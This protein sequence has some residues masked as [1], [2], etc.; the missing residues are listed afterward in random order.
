MQHTELRTRERGAY[1]GQPDTGRPVTLASLASL[2]GNWLHFSAKVRHGG[3][4]HPKQ[5]TRRPAACCWL[6]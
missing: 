6:I 4:F 3:P 2:A 1:Q 5:A